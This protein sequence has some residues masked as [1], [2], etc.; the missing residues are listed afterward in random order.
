MLRNTITAFF[1]T[2]VK[3]TP[4][5]LDIIDD[6]KYITYQELDQRVTQCAQYLQFIGVRPEMPVAVCMLRSIDL[7]ISILAIFKAGGVY[8]PLEASYP[9]ERLHFILEDSNAY[10]LIVHP[11]FAD[12][13]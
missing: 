3:R 12:K 8:L 7:L 13:F 11:Q 2:Q 6:D 1:T 4:E 10:C 9:V 5:Q